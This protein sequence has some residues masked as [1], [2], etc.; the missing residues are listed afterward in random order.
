MKKWTRLIAAMVLAIFLLTGCSGGGF[1]QFFEDIYNSISMG[2]ATSFKDMEY[3]RPD[4]DAFEATLAVTLEMAKTEKNVKTLM[5]SVTS[6][7]NMY[8]SFYTNHSL[9]NIHYC[10]SYTHRSSKC[11]SY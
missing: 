10:T 1:G 8:Y 4:V 3:V 5:S 9:A 2:A 11:R 7:Y 6:L